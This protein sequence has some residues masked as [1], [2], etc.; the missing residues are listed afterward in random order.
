MCAEWAGESKRG[1]P[2]ARDTDRCCSADAWLP[3]EVVEREPKKPLF[4]PYLDE[5]HGRRAS[6]RPRSPPGSPPAE[7][8]DDPR[9]QKPRA[10]AKLQR[11]FLTGQD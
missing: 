5:E 10:G 2:Q 1:L 6:C 11:A 8:W 7:P 4:E 9:S 3:E